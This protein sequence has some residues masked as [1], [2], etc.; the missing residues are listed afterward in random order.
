MVEQF[1]LTVLRTTNPQK[2]IICFSHSNIFLFQCKSII[3]QLLLPLGT[4]F[5]AVVPITVVTSTSVFQGCPLLAKIVNFA[6]NKLYKI[7]TFHV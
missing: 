3:T 1:F 6:V 7:F 4:G 2:S 5:P